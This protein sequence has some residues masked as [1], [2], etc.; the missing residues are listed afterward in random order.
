MS[1][2]RAAI[3]AVALA[4]AVVLAPLT[5]HAA[6]DEP[7]GRAHP[8]FVEGIVD[9]DGE[10]WFEVCFDRSWG[11][12]PPADVF[13][14]FWMLAI[15][16]GDQTAQVGWQTHDGVQTYLGEAGTRAYLLDNGCILLA[17]GLHP[18]G[19]Y[20]VTI[21]AQ[22]AS[23]LDEATTEAISGE[24]SMGTASRFIDQGDPMTAFGMP[25][26]D[27]TSGQP[28]ATSTTVAVTTSTGS[29]TSTVAT[30]TTVTSASDGGGNGILFVMLGVVAILAFLIWFLF[31]FGYL[32]TKN[33]YAYR[34][35][36]P[37]LENM[38]EEADE[39]GDTDSAKPEPESD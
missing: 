21:A 28:V 13:S 19:D 24:T 31:R 38:V 10:L 25:I 18:T 17:T 30:S 9:Q 4:T 20:E 15:T 27:L 26:V 23:W 39:A 2:F 32:P 14:L 33:R 8:S 34:V 7:D 35:D 1:G 3:T 37:A 22:F 5:A 11:D 6:D 16:I 29:S 12:A 36:T